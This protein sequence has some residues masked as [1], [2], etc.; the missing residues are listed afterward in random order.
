MTD[1]LNAADFLLDG[2][3]ANRVA[4]RLLERDFT[5]GELQA[6]ANEF[7]TTLLA[8]GYSRGDRV[9]LLSVNSFHWAAAYLGIL[10][11]GLVC[12]PLPANVPAGE[13]A[14]YVGN[15]EPRAAFLHQPLLPRYKATLADAGIAVFCEG[16]D[17]QGNW[18]RCSQTPAAQPTLQ[19]AVADVPHDLAALMFTSGSTGRPRG[20]MVTHRNLIANTNSILSC[21]NL[22]EHERMMTV[23][24]FH[25]CFGT[26]LLHTYSRVGAVLVIDNRFTYPEVVLERMAETQ[27]T[28]FA[29]VPSHYQILLRTSSLGRKPL[30]HLRSLLQAGGHLAPRFVHELQEKLPQARI[31]IMY[32]QTEATARLTCLPPESLS[33]KPGSIGKAIPGVRLRILKHSGE[34]AIP[35]E[36]GELVAEGENVTLG[37]WRAPE[38]SAVTFREGKLHTG[39][40]GTMDPDGF[41]YVVERER[42]FVKCGGVR[43]SCR[44][45]EDGL[46]KCPELVEAIVVAVSDELLGEAA[47]AFV[48]SRQEP[49]DGVA[50]HVRNFCRSHLPR[51]MIPRDIIVIPEIPRNSCGKVLRQQLKTLAGDEPGDR[52]LEL[53]TVE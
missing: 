43:I 24:P 25:Y 15:T 18:F 51:N 6:A 46:V 38:E 28:S 48:V 31:F 13:L 32:G 47:R 44:H 42:E 27:C 9:L 39:D 37:Y 22:E 35:G 53:S 45:M 41:L 10:K 26:S 52:L 17:H 34:E 30:P 8:A 33:S 16:S 12:V 4:L 29:G 7:A 21:L 3:R 49:S 23:L 14:Y 50:Q 11:A 2:N 36:I 5:F 1:S 20:V 19:N 40:L